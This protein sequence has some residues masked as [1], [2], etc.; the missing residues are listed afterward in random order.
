MEPR[1]RKDRLSYRSS[2][3]A[4]D[5]L[6]R[7]LLVAIQTRSRLLDFRRVVDHD[8][9]LVQSCGADNP[10]TLDRDA[11]RSRAPASLTYDGNSRSP[12]LAWRG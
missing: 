8:L 2:G 7:S 3:A 6:H 12:Q 9:G 11:Q 5:E 4:I 1:P 10:V